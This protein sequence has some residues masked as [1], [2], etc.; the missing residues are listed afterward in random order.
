M[1]ISF[2]QT[3]TN[4]ACTIIASSYCSTF[5]I[6]GQ[7]PKNKQATVGGTPGVASNTQNVD[8]SAVDLDQ[9]S[10]EC[11]VPNGYDG[12]AGNWT[13]RLNVTTANANITWDGVTI[14]RMN[15]AC[16]SQGT[17][18]ASVT[19]GISLASTGVKS[20]TK[21]GLFQSFAGGDKVIVI[22]AFSN[23][24]GT[25]QSFAFTPDQLIDSPYSII[26][27]Q[28]AGRNWM[29]YNTSVRM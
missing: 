18:V 8:P 11:V 29:Y 5:I 27:I 24:A 1:A 7:L 14:C 10:F 20:T 6:G 21:T 12:S 15:S 17:I 28:D 16:V 2:Q 13:V 19:L 23:A 22:L 25:T 9:M 26:P 4:S 3:D